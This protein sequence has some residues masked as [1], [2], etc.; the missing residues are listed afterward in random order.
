MVSF[1]N[2]HYAIYMYFV[3]R[4]LLFINLELLVLQITSITS[5]S[6]VVN[7]GSLATRKT[8]LIGFERK[9]PRTNC[10]LPFLFEAPRLE[11]E[12]RQQI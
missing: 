11:V 10:L 4:L 6:L 7:V 9:P 3:V 12:H 2:I 5:R 1:V 8:L